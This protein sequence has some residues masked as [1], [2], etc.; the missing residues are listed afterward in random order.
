MQSHATISAS[1]PRT[2]GTSPRHRITHSLEFCPQRVAPWPSVPELLVSSLVPV[3]F[4]F[5]FP[6]RLFF[7]PSY[8]DVSP[9]CVRVGS[10]ELSEGWRLLCPGGPALS[11]WTC[12]VLVDLPL[13]ILGGFLPPF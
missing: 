2:G 13:Y 5:F 8:C 1:L 4:L 6:C 11:W 10:L 12:P 9:Y 3:Q 7:C